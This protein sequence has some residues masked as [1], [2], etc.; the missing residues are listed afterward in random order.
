MG[1]GAFFSSFEGDGL[2]MFDAKKCFVLSHVL[3]ED[4]GCSQYT[5]FSGFNLW[6]FDVICCTKMAL[7][8]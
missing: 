5:F 7:T 8:M 2:M 1:L 4:I 6:K 3:V